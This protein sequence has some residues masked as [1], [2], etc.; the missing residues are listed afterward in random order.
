MPRTH[1]TQPLP[2]RFLRR[3]E[4]V[5]EYGL[6][7]STQRQLERE[8]KLQTFRPGGKRLVLISRESLERLLK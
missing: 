1:L 2:K 8:G 4:V 7:L 5:Q 3:A 6:S